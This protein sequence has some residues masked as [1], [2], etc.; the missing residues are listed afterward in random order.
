MSIRLFFR[1]GHEVV[2]TTALG[3]FVQISIKY[4]LKVK[5]GSVVL[6]L[7]QTRPESVPQM[8]LGETR[9]ETVHPAT[10]L[11]GRHNLQSCPQDVCVGIVTTTISPVY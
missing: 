11:P 10:F 1:T 5:A 4:I 8:T 9:A 7:P 6:A 3:V 2:G